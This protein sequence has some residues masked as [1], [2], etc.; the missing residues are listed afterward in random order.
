M[1]QRELSERN[2]EVTQRGDT[3]LH[4]FAM[5]GDNEV[6]TAAIRRDK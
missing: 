1:R 2:C 3:H 4:D 5:W 6:Y